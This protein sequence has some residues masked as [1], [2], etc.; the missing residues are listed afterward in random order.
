MTTAAPTT[1][2]HLR[3]ASLD[4]YDEIAR[5][6]AANGI[7]SFPR[8]DWLNL[9]L[10]NPLW[11][12]L[13][14]DWP[15]GWIL[16]DTG[17]RLVGSLVNIPSLYHFRG[18]ELI[19]A[20]GRG[21]AVDPAYRG[22]AMW[23]MEEYFNQSG[24]DLFI[25]TTVGPNAAP[26]LSSLSDRVPLGDLQTL[27]YWVTGYCGFARKALTKLHVPLAGL[28]AFPAAAALRL[29]DA[30]SLKSLPPAD[31]S[32]AIET[33]DSFDSRFD[34]F[35]EELVRTTPEKLLASRTRAALAWHYAV[36]L[37][38]GRLWVFTASR[39]RLMRAYAILKRQDTNDGVRRMQLVDYQS[40]DPPDELLP[41][42]L[43]AA[44]NRCTAEGF[45]MLEHLGCGL[46]KTAVFDRHAPYRRKLP[47]WPF[48]YLAPDPALK[49]EL[50]RPDVWDPSAFDGDASLD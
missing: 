31:S 38:L 34:V 36:P 11:P 13:N 30:V 19:C 2:P 46:P 8:E 15:I 47:C 33:I 1:S 18:R 5:L 10:Q 42:L 32:V 21:W 43:Q 40:L 14:N 6:E 26:A 9:W 41:G 16:A 3:P 23:L 27:A 45:Y 39:G 22:F 25:N 20:N 29:K 24:A 4:D 7:G 48:Y 50:A 12:R 17:G 28:L 49:A 35:W 37:R 44:L